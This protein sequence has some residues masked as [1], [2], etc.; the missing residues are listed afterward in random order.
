MGL[1]DGRL[2]LPATAEAHYQS[3]A[4]GCNDA[5][6]AVCSPGMSELEQFSQ[7]RFLQHEITT[8]SR[9]GPLP[10]LF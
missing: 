4:K 10:F 5:R 3:R 1:G 7:V 9:V 2:A 8:K 6:L